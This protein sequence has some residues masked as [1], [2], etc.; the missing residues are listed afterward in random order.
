MKKNHT[1][2]I[3]FS[4]LKLLPSRASFLQAV[5]ANQ[6]AKGL[7]YQKFVGLRYEG[8]TDQQIIGAICN[9]GSFIDKD[10]NKHKK[11]FL[12]DPDPWRKDFF[13]LVDGLR[14]ALKES[15]VK[16]MKVVF[17]TYGFVQCEMVNPNV[18]KKKGGKR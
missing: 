11:V 10:Y 1:T 8:G 9:I 7:L 17:E 14:L 16:T 2:E 12:C 4:N 18:R 15:G 5:L 3:D 6:K 13:D